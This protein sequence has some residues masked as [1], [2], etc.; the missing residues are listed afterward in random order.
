MKV[1]HEI[2]GQ[3][4]EWHDEKAASNWEKHRVTFFEACEV[5][6]D[7]FVRV[8]D[9]SDIGEMRGGAIGFSLAARLLFVVHTE[10]DGD[11]TRIISA[12][13]ATRDE[14]NQ[15]EES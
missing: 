10:A 12:R 11:T 7:P 9:A 15:Y 5:L 3:Q 1:T 14:R 6:L 2:D 13:R 4:F 8:I